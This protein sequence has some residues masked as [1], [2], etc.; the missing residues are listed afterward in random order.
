MSFIENCEILNE[1]FYI[2]K[3]KVEKFCF[4]FE[5]IEHWTIYDEILKLYSLHFLCTC[6][7]ISPQD[8]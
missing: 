8:V 3:M 2:K 5:Q 1:V 7:L 4:S 6:S